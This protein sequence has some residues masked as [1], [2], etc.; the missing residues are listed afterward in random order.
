MRRLV[1]FSE[2]STDWRKFSEK[3]TILWVLRRRQEGLKL[4]GSDSISIPSQRVRC[5]SFTFNH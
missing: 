2:N 1:I 4:I 5:T 3:E